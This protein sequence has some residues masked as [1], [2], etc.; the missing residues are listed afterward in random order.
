MIE[1]ASPWGQP[2]PFSLLCILGDLGCCFLTS[3]SISFLICKMGRNVAHCVV[4]PEIMYCPVHRRCLKTGVLPLLGIFDPEPSG[5]CNGLGMVACCWAFLASL[6][7]VRHQCSSDPWVEMG[8]HCLARGLYARLAGP[9][10]VC[11][12]LGVLVADSAV[13]GEG[14]D[15]CLLPPLSQLLNRG[16]HSGVCRGLPP[17]RFHRQQVKSQVYSSHPASSREIFPPQV[18]SLLSS[19]PTYYEAGAEKTGFWQV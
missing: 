12:R 8:A 3:Q 13:S 2:Q 1:W 11:V 14:T 19:P 4:V 5:D 17:P 7:P 9:E 10:C 6:S 18:L 16:R 15:L